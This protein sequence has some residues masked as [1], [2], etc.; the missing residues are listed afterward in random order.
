MLLK[1]NT[2]EQ[3]ITGKSTITIAKDFW[4][5]LL[6][7]VTPCPH[8]HADSFAFWSDYLSLN[9]TSTW[10]SHTS[11]NLREWIL[12]SCDTIMLTKS[13][14][15]FPLKIGTSS[16]DHCSLSHTVLIFQNQVSSVPNYPFCKSVQRSRCN[17]SSPWNCQAQFS[18]P[19]ICGVQT[20]F[21]HKIIKFHSCMILTLNLLKKTI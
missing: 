4:L 3:Y 19:H 21:E 5:S 10:L 17:C 7:S 18:S 12:H 16:L 15:P 2:H 14:L 8:L 13:M 1:W 9:T 20:S 11:I 6:V